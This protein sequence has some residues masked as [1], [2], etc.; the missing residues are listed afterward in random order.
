MTNDNLS[1]FLIMA[2]IT[3]IKGNIF[4]STC[5]VLVNTVN[6][7]GIM[8]KGIAL[9]FK[10]RFPEM[11][12]RYVE[13]CEDKLLKP[14]MLFLWTK[15]IPWV[16][17]FPTKNHWRYPS[18]IEYIELSL[19]KFTQTYKQK[20]ISSIAFPTLGTHSGGLSWPEVSSLMY[21]YLAILDN[22]EIEIYHYDPTAEDSLFDKFY[23]RV[24]RF[25]VNDYVRIIGLTRKQGSLLKVV[26]GNNDVKTMVALQEIK[27]LGEKSLE[28]IYKFLQKPPS[29]IITDN[30]S[31][32]KL[33]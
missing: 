26:I 24:H 1:G 9:E 17:N 14:G 5:K 8:G 4:E 2:K 13:M 12:I 6:C 28:K 22:L 27:G 31:Q 30:E 16:L 33:F 21:S 29:H 23:Q 32:M 19:K 15:S 20:R 3:E 11:Y 18:K 7:V 10:N 25:E